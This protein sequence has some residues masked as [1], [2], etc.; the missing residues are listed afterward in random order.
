MRIKDYT[1]TYMEKPGDPVIRSPT[2]IFEAATGK[3]AYKRPK[4]KN[5]AATD[6]TVY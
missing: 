3:T 4:N 2:E 1:Y 6:K 5:G